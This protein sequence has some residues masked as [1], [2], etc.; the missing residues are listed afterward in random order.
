MLANLGWIALSVGALVAAVL[1]LRWYATFP[2]ELPTE[3]AKQPQQ[4]QRPAN[5]VPMRRRASRQ[6]ASRAA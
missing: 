4:A 1:L 5:V 6:E 2:A 3:D